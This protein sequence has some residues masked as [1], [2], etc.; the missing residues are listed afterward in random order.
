MIASGSGCND[1][2]HST[3]R[4]AVDGHGYTILADTTAV[5]L[6]IFSG[7]ASTRLGRV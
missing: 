1:A 3:L 5:L 4:S 6:A 7:P 2:M